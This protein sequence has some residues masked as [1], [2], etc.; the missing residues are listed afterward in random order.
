MANMDSTRDMTATKE[1]VLEPSSLKGST[2]NSQ[3]GFDRSITPKSLI[4]YPEELHKPNKEEC[5]KSNARVMK[6]L[7]KGKMHK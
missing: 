5:L 4:S 7:M 2:V 6:H 1:S 3:A